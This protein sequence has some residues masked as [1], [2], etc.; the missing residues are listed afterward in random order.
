MALLLLVLL[1]GSLPA[2]NVAAWFAHGAAGGRGKKKVKVE[3]QYRDLAG[4]KVA[5][6]V[7]ADEYIQGRYPSSVLA[8]SR[9]VS[10]RIVGNLPD[11][12]IVPPQDLIEFQKKNPYWIT[13]M[14]GEL[15]RKLDVERLIIID[16]IE[17]RTHEPGNAWVWQGMIAGEINVMEAESEDPD[18]PSF[19]TTVRAQYPEEGELGLVNSDNETVE[20][21]MLVLFA[22]DAA[23]LFYDHEVM[24]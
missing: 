18:N 14:P 8:V 16:L 1:A 6:L 21:G 19:S 9:A 4:K 20:L 23:G 2:C 17:Y 10:A 3:A 7:A 12:T 13:V 22:R 24:R 15:I 11:T 5:V